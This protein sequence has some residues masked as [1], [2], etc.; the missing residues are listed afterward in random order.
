MLIEKE[1][2]SIRAAWEAA[3]AALPKGK[4]V[5]AVFPTAKYQTVII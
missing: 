3:Q 5:P 2:L 1:I 4:A